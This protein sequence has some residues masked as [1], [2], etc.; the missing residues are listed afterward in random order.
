VTTYRLDLER[1]S[2]ARV[3]DFLLEGS[4]H[5]LVDRAFGEALLDQFPEFRAI[6]R[7]NH[8][9]VNRAVRHLVR[10]G[11][12]Q[13]VN[14]GSGVLSERNTHQVADESATCRVVY[15][16][17][18]PIAIA[19]TELLLDQEGD[20][21]RHAVVDADLRDPDQVWERVLR[22]KIINPARPLAV[23]MFSVM[24]GLKP[25]P[26]ETST[27]DEAVR[28]VAR[29][30]DRIPV[31]SY[32]GISHV[33]YDDLPEQ[34]P[35]KL[36]ELRALYR[37]W[38]GAGIDSRSKKGI[39]AFLGDFELVEPGLTWISE[40][41]PESSGD[42]AIDVFPTPAHSVVW[43]GIGRKKRSSRRRSARG[44]RSR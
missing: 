17:N 33:A 9:F 38:C 22:T 20:P 31:G 11:V 3:Y 34:L 42:T 21:D 18:D 27:D 41:H 15:V 16:D 13:F 25:G 26:D 23:L 32:L 39:E 28:L 24:H 44:R 30:R 2:L 14:I 8:Q 4:S 35:E 36:R 5:W 40:W 1:P 37:K 10:L 6:A 7:A 29:F 43:G 12:R 19:N